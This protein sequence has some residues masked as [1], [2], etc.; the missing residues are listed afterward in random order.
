MNERKNERMKERTK[1]RK[2]KEERKKEERNKVGLLNITNSKTFIGL[3][4]QKGGWR[5]VESGRGGEGKV[6]ERIIFKVKGVSI[7]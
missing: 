3:N 7:D 5:R 4:P 2:K 6:P 1:G